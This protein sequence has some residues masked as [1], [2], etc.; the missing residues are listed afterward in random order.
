M[1]PYA[2][3]VWVYEVTIVCGLTICVLFLSP[4]ERE[5]ERRCVCVCERECVCALQHTH[6]WCMH[7]CMPVRVS[8]SVCGCVCVRV[9]V[10]VRVALTV[11]VC[12]CVF[13][14]VFV[15]V[16]RSSSERGKTLNSNFQK[17]IKARYYICLIT[18]RTWAFSS[19][20][21]THG[22]LSYGCMRP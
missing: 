19:S 15:R 6:T 13:A 20:S 22:A 1:R 12:V 10:R 4:R 5:S 17:L 14:C 11:C 18:G 9:R 2:T 7:A 16:F 3:S 21:G 8:V